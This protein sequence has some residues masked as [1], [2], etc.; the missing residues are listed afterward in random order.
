MMLWRLFLVPNHA[1]TTSI[2]DES[3]EIGVVCFLLSF[4]YFVKHGK[5]TM[6]LFLKFPK[7]KNKKYLFVARCY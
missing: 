4:L 1:F 7:P 2:F 6:N 3:S 5:F